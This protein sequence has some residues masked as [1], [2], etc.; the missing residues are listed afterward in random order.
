MIKKTIFFTF[1][2]FYILGFSQKYEFDL[3]CNMVQSHVRG[4]YKNSKARNINF[5]FNTQNNSYFSKKDESTYR[6]IIDDKLG[7]KYSFEEAVYQ[8]K[9]V[10]TNVFGRK[11]NDNGKDIVK[12]RLVVNFLEKNTYQVKVFIKDEIKKPTLIIKFILR[13]TN[14]PLLRFDFLDADF[15]FRLHNLI[16]DSLESNLPHKNFQVE[17]I[18]IDYKKGS[19]VLY[20]SKCESINLDYL[21]EF[22]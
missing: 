22:K 3:D 19:E 6:V 7:V 2:F 12:Y 8:N 15:E 14:Y 9:L 20:L 13:E 16:F 5:L 17:G 11:I 10:L 4:I 18:Q 1:L 21:V